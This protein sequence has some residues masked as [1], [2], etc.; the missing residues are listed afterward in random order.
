MAKI[1]QFDNRTI[2]ADIATEVAVLRSPVAAGS[3]VTLTLDNNSELTNVD[4][5]LVEDIA[6]GRAEIAQINQAVTAGTNI[7]VATLKFPHNAGVKIYRL[8]YNKIQFYH[9]ATV[10][11]SK[12][13]LGS[14][15]DLDVDDE[16][17]EYVDSANTTGYAFFRL[18]NST[19]SDVSDYSSA[20]PYSL[21]ALTSKSKIREFVRKFYKGDIDSETFDF[22]CDTAE[23][24]IFLIYPWRFREAVFTFNTVLDQQVYSFASLGLTDF[25]QLAAA[26]YDDEPM[27]YAT[28]KE[29]RIL[30][31]GDASTPRG[32]AVMNIWNN[33]ITITPAPA[34]SDLEVTLYYWKRSGGFDEETSDTAITLPQAIAYAILQDLWANEDTKKSQFWEGRKMQ[35][36]GLL[37]KSNT[38]QSTRFPSLTKNSMTRRYPDDQIENPSI[39]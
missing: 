24:E 2:F 36:I 34:E 5:V 10:A 27:E 33:E 26:T 7:R 11:G 38:K 16:F 25:Q 18:K 35:M 3:D 8:K 22:L 9:A 21:L 4:Y 13:Q 1:L 37:K 17:T 28:F 14:D 23:Q 32:V 39:G 19:T 6:T 12:S 20:Y 15:T 30:N 29:N 31:W